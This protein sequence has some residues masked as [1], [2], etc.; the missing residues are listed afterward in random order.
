MVTD[1][2]PEASEATWCGFR[3][4]FSKASRWPNAAAGSG[5]GRVLSDAERATRLWLAISVATLWLLSVGGEADETIPDST[6]LDVTGL[7]PGPPACTCRGGGAW[8]VSF[9]V[10]GI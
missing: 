9:V 1:L 6:L 2:A 7:C 4:R 8:S 3:T 5:S 10:G